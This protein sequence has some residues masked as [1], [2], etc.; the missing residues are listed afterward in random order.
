MLI[1]MLLSLIASAQVVVSDSFQGFSQATWTEGVA[2]GQWI[3]EYH[4]Y[5]K[6]GIHVDSGTNKVLFQSPMASKTPDETHA[7]LVL[8]KKSYKTSRITL[9][10]KTVKQL[11]TPVPNP[12][13]TAWVVWNYEHDHKFYYFAFK[14]NGWELGKVD[15]AKVNPNGPECLWPEYLN[16]KY[17]GAQRY[18]KTG[19]S[20][21]LKINKWDSIRVDQ[22]GG[23]LTVFVNNVQVTT[24]TDKENVYTKGRM[25]MYNEDAYV[26]FD[27]VQVTAQP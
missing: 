15:N 18:L 24:F 8:T 6:V 23:K 12:W 1:L 13:E 19:N 5:G 2:K 25:G 20:P 21:A 11:R 22:V 9:R 27:D 10:S 3:T 14:T 7:S 4:G 26:R 16:C 17:E